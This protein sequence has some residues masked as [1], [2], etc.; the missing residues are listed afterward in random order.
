MKII[1]ASILIFTY[2]L[3]ANASMAQDSIVVDSV[4]QT[5][6]CAGGTVVIPYSLPNGDFN[7]GN[8]FT[9]QLSG[10]IDPGCLLNNF[11]NP[12]DIGLLPYWSSGF[13]LAQI[14]DSITFGT[15]R[16]RIISS[17]PPDTS[18]ISPNCVL[19]TNIPTIIFTIAGNPS[20]D[21]LCQGDSVELSVLP[22]PISYEWSTGETT[23]TIWV[24]NSGSYTVTARDTL[25]CETTSDPYTVEF[26]NCVGLDDQE[27]QLTGLK[28]HPVP[29]T[30]RIDI[31]FTARVVGDIELYLYNLLGELLL[32][33]HLITTAGTNH[34]SLDIAFLPNGVYLLRVGTGTA[35][36]TTK[37][38]KH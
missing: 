33:N 7:F 17:D 36:E 2:L 26:E 31:S 15:Y 28:A 1:A 23:S 18:N 22:L 11:G 37:L 27:L 32:K 5:S 6:F 12:L 4:I 30:N 25:G 29:S 10:D 19:I 34:L 13:M 35:F 38:V 8:V 21:T 16:L 9:A 20:D 14:P 3:A 24:S